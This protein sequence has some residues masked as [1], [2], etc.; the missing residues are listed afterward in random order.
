[1]E[2]LKKVTVIPS[3]PERIKDL[4]ELSMNMY[5]TWNFNAQKLFEN[6]DPILWEKTGRNPVTFLKS[7]SQKE[8]KKAAESSNYLE[9]YDNEMKKFSSYKNEKNTWF[10]ATHKDYTGGKI[11]YFCAEF[12]LHESLPIYTG[13]LGILAGDHVKSAS[14]L[15]IPFVAIGMIYR[16]GYFIQKIRSDGTQ[17]DLYEYY[18]YE[19]FPIQ[20]AKNES[21]EEVYVTV[22]ILNRTVYIKA[23]ELAVGRVKL[24]LLDT[25][26]PQNEP[27]DRHLTYKLYGG[28]IEMRIKQEIVLGIGGIR[29]LRKLGIDTSVYHMNDSH[30]NFLVLERIRELIEEKAFTPRQA[31]EYV[32]STSIFTTHTPVPAG[33]DSFHP[34]LM[35]KY[36]KEYVKNLN[37]TWE[38]FLELGKEVRTD[39]TQMFS[40][41]ILALKLAGR[42]N[43]VSKLHG[44]VSR[45]LWKD[46]WPGLEAVEVPITHVTN[47]VHS[48]TWIANELQDLYDKY[49]S[50]CWRMKQDDPEIWNKIDDIPDEELWAVHKKLKKKLIAFTHERLKEQRMRHGETVEQIQEIEGI[51]DENALTIGF[52][53]RFATY[54]RALM[55]F[56][57]LN[58]LDAILN[59]P[60]K[61]VQIIFAGKAHPADKP[62]QELIRRINEISRMPNF[63]NKIVF[64]EGYDMNV[65]RHLLAGVD[66]WMNTP[67]RP[68]EASGTSG[69]KAGMNGSINFSVLDGWWVEGYKGNNGWA[70][71]DNRDYTD[72][73]LQDKI[74]S[75]SIYNTLEKIIVPLYYSGKMDLSYEW[76][77]IIK[78]S[79]KSISAFFNTSRMLKEYT[80]RL[81][82]PAYFQGKKFADNDFKISKE[83][84]RWREILEKNWNSV[85]IKVIGTQDIT[86]NLLAGTKVEIQ[87][88]I[89]LP[90]I[91]P[92]S[93]KVEAVVAKID[94]Q[95]VAHL[96]S[97]DFRLIKEVSPDTYLYSGEIEF[98]E[99]G[100]Y[101]YNIRVAAHHNFMPHRNYIMNLVK[102][103]G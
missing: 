7:V 37:L 15:G 64:I 50:P 4:K 32:R 26:I 52:A 78:E 62:G 97:Y 21:N 27:E 22:N 84:S 2:F 35:E 57:D 30:P 12:G 80:Q 10:N 44:E 8:L 74:D 51:L 13:G 20:P 54:K 11:A 38:E 96:K 77:D 69:E 82:M 58:R 6:I 41:T 81:Y 100:T 24:Y 90:G 47:G 48:E 103:P 25:D 40:M 9:L 76:T 28:D 56:K 1:M 93:I 92:D 70:I 95:K 65:A 102:Y 19:N 36:F 14:D 17:E 5:W 42:A 101:G 16:Q 53:R 55:I 68:H 67:R 88:E 98:D 18:N 89:Y 63:K 3:L 49:L 94:G 86:N 33:N 23:W 34:N 83:F 71:G 43:G 85:K 66:V 31:I 45:N 99:R 59:N 39:G 91:G 79:I 75:V 46:V 29:M 73:E 60:E 61:P 87:S 72:H